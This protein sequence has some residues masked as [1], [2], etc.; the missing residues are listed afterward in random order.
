[1]YYIYDFD[2]VLLVYS[3]SS[4]GGSPPSRG[5]SIAGEPK[6]D[7]PQ[8]TVEAHG[9]KGP[10]V[11]AA[12]GDGV[13]VPGAAIAAGVA[14]L[15]VVADDGS[16]APEVLLEGDANVTVGE[17]ATGDSAASSGPARG[18][19]PST[20][21]ADDDVVL[22]ESGVILGHPMLRAPRDVSLDEVMG[23]ARW[24]LTQTQDVLRR[25]SGGIND[26]W[27]CLLL[28]ASILKEQ[29]MTEKARAEARQHH[30]DVREELLNKLQVAINSHDRDSQKMLVD[31]KELY[32][33]AEAQANITIKQE[34]E[35]D[36]YICAIVEQER[37]MD[38]LE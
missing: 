38:E 10:T 11:G 8:D 16:P 35:L 15:E 5:S 34:E 30:L 2:L 31:A 12:G 27:Q 22:E 32:A 25:E 28:W 9:S 17:M 36:A 7:G 1:L 26:E 19:S 33:S 3:V 13:P 4:S 20:V 23:M 29:T 14:V 6:A 24:A 37:A 21:V 18:T